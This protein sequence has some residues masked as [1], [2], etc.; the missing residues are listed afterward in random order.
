LYIR[1]PNQKVL[2]ANITSFVSNIARRVDFD[3]GIRYSDDADKAV[4]AMKA[5][6]DAQT[7]ILKQP[8]PLVF[9]SDLGDNAVMIAIR[10]WAPVSEWFG[11]KTQLLL[12]L[13]TLLEAEGIEI[14][15][16][17]RS[18]WFANDLGTREVRPTD[19]RRSQQKNQ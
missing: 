15:F 13:K 19:S 6:L 2:T 7:M 12:K 3:V 14:P 4:N 9:V 16:P 18:V 8:E 1:L 5:F 10:V 11:L 17:Q